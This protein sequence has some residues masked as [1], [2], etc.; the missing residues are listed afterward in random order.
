MLPTYYRV[1]DRTDGSPSG[2]LA[3]TETRDEWMPGRDRSS[4]RE[5][6]E[7]EIREVPDT[8]STQSPVVN[9]P[10]R[11]NRSNKGQTNKFKDYETDF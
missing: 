11:S 1:Q 3:E 10:R 6:I 4:F 2:A 9:P 7:P 5:S 8:E